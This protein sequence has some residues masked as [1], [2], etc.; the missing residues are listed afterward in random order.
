MPRWDNPPPPREAREYYY[1]PERLAYMREYNRN[2]RK[3]LRGG[4]PSM[5]FVERGRLGGRTR[6]AN[7]R[8]KLKKEGAA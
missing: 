8:K 1:S 4:T 5:S 6:V 3:M 7:L 2:Y